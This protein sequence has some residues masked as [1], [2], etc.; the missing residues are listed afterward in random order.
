[1]RICMSQA[2][3]QYL[4]K[5]IAP[6]GHVAQQVRQLGTRFGHGARMSC[7]VVTFAAGRA[8]WRTMHF[9]TV[10]SGYRRILTVASNNS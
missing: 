2:R 1:M 8:A 7:G 6:G 3:F 4:A 9:S 10:Y 5:N